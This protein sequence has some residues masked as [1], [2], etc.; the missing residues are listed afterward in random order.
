MKLVR[1]RCSEVEGVTMNL[2]PPLSA[3]PVSS[4]PSTPA[5]CPPRLHGA[6]RLFALSFSM[7]EARIVQLIK[8]QDF[9]Q[10]RTVMDPSPF[11]STGSNLISQESQL[12][13]FL[14][15]SSCHTTIL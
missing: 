12:S 14:S 9:Y 15:G 7:W 6:P 1:V 8:I 2:E 5:R 11:S 10:T 4:V 3:G 13:S